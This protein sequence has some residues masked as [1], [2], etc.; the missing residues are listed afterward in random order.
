MDNTMPSHVLIVMRTGPLWWIIRCLKPRHTGPLCWMTRCLATTYCDAHWSCNMMDITMSGHDVS[1]C[2]CWSCL[3]GKSRL[4]GGWPKH[5]VRRFGVYWRWRCSTWSSE[6]AA[7]CC[8]SWS[9]PRGTIGG[10]RHK[11]HFC[12]DK[13]FCR[14][15]YVFVA[16]KHVFYHDKSMLVTTKHLSRQN[17]VCRDNHVFVTTKVY[18]SRKA[19]VCR[20]KSFVVTKLF[21]RDK[22]TSVATSILLIE[23]TEAYWR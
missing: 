18:L 4:S 9:V 2:R 22:H 23:H 17:Y 8:H 21:C 14:D 7:T 12:R 19:R 6:S 5:V 10:S 11:Y 3:R 13:T 15:K 1:E 16:T 20:D